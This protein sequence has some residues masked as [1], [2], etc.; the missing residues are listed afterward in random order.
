MR[1][2]SILIVLLAVPAWADDSAA[3]TILEKRCLACHGEARMSGLDLR[4]REA[5]LTGGKRGSALTPGDP[6]KS[7]LFRVVSGSGDLKMPPGKETLSRDEVE[8]LR[9]WIL[10]GAQW[11]GDASIQAAEPSWWSFKKLK[12]PPIP[13]APAG[14]NP[15]D[16]FVLPA[17]RANHL[18]AA[19]PADR[20][21]LIR[22]AYF[23]LIGLPPEPERVEKF[24]NDSSPDAWPKLI[25]ELLASPR[26]GE[27]WGRHWLD[28]VRYAD[29]GGYETDIYFRNA[30]RYRDYVIQSFN[31]D[32]PYDRFVQ[33]QI[34]GD[35]IW[36]NNLDL[37][38]TYT[39][40]PKKVQSLQARIGTGMF[41]IG[42]EVHE[43]NMDATKLQYEK[44]TDY[45][46]TL[47]AAFLGVT[48]GC[49]RCHDHKFDPITQRDYFRLAA[50]FALSTETDIPVVHGMSIRDHGQNYPRIIAV[51][52]SKTALK[53]FD[54]KLRKRLVEARKSQFS[55]E[56]LAAYEV[57]EEQRTAKQKE[58]IAPLEEALV[59]IKPDKEMSAEEAG[60]RRKLL[61][62]IG[63][64]VAAV[65]EQDAQKVP[66]DGLMDIPS[67]TVLGHREPELVPETRLYGRGDLSNKGEKVGPGLPAFLG[68]GDLNSDDCS[69]RCIPL[70][71]KKLALWLTQA[72]HPLT[73]RVMVNRIWHW[74]FGRGIVASPNDFGRQGLA[75]AMP[76]LLDWLASEFVSRGWS[77]KAMHRLIMLSDTYRRTSRFQNEHNQRVDPDNRFHWRMNRRRLEGEALWD[78]MHSV[79][80]TLNLKAGGRPV[81][82]PLAED[83]RSSLG[84]AWQWPVSADPEQ[85]NRR[86]VY[87]LV[88]RNF[89]YPM[90]EAFD[91]PIN[92]VSCPGRDVSSVAPQ[93]LW[94]LNNRVAFEQAKAFAARLRKEHGNEPAAWVDAAWRLALSRP[95]SAEETEQAV[96]LIEGL[97]LEKFCLSVFNL[98]EYAY[99][100]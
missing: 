34:A 54:G 4:K 45:V 96:R 17:L 61:E 69:G 42:P 23:D 85:H 84:A 53:L 10:E 93:A 66:F 5:V 33:E 60:Q 32:K 98:N 22:R 68:G 80:G 8:T 47:G 79:A 29:S 72:D 7:L 12:R 31:D 3:R 73:A 27:R 100:D 74:H 52:E 36:P 26:Y 64:A 99:V 65:P 13:E 58:L 81:V 28:V 86:G 76:E 70:A 95:A 75:P 14:S 97:S 57:K 21:T 1:K 38:G 44:V 90:F 43:S 92:A 18:T 19:P 37:D 25:D 87:I 20:H 94:F 30:W 6:A 83:E 88:R 67:A 71:R 9:T 89:T 59:S 49:A 40:D 2:L 46:D 51:D 24:V 15:I 48:T 62:D 16:A 50:I 39:L 55:P 11:P 56:V 91:S 41:T 82:P 63:K 77:I 78:A 35:E